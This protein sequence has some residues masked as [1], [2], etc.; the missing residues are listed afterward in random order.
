M[1]LQPLINRFRSLRLQIILALSFVLL[2]LL[3]ITYFFISSHIILSEGF[4]RT[5][6]IDN[7]AIRMAIIERDI[8]DMQRNV[9][10]YKESSSLIAKKNVQKIYDNTTQAIEEL[11]QSDP[12]QPFTDTLT[13][14][15]Y[16]LTEYNTNFN[17]VVSYLS[18]VET[19]K[20]ELVDDIYLNGISKEAQLSLPL[21]AQFHIATA[22][23]EALMYLN[24]SN[25]QHINNTKK[26][27]KNTLDQLPTNKNDIR[28]AINAFQQQVDRLVTVK[29]NYTYL[30][31]VVMAGNANE[32]LYNA[33]LLSTSL[34][35]LATAINTQINPKIEQQESIALFVSATGILL[36]LIIGLFFYKTITR[37]IKNITEIFI[38]LTQGDNTA[39]ISGM[40]RTDEI[41]ALAK[42]AHVFKQKNEQTVQL[43]KETEVAYE[44]QKH[45]NS[46]L[47]SEKYR[48]EKAL[49]VRTNFLANMSHELRTPL[50]SIIGFTVRL[51]KKPETLS[52]RQHSA[53]E[54][55][56]R[57]GEH[58]L[59][60]INDILDLSKLEANK[61][62]INISVV[63]VSALML[64]CIEQVTVNSDEKQLPINYQKKTIETHTDPIRLRQIILNV[65]SNSIKYTEQGH[66]DC[67]ISI[68]PGQQSFTIRVADTGIGI[69]ETDQKQ[70][71]NRFSQFGDKSK[72]QVGFGTG[73]GLAIV[74]NITHLLGGSIRVESQLGKGTTIIINLPIKLTE[75]TNKHVNNSLVQSNK[76]TL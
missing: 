24:T 66:I 55:V 52:S 19:L 71:F 53:L 74:N 12:V 49:N 18:Q 3:I 37:P 23:A 30:V 54:A 1:R 42:A 26:H 56:W 38:R 40:E 8:I 31:N 39:Y 69:S 45:L 57:N 5:S 36:A 9:Y 25:F 60:M 46:Q 4:Q 14:M 32:I 48:A 20:S 76:T 63:D 65:L 62:D 73:L 72:Q 17:I 10:L 11:S 22:K 6:Q 35:Q 43:L 13:D 2:P 47:E 61:L 16:H 28:T 34:E 70:L 29:R 41:G 51:L 64:E 67:D 68:D 44:V 50:N 33:N 15:K 59:S 75:K 21:K 7:I 58:L 27:L